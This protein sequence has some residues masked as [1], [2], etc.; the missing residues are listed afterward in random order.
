METY[1]ENR[2]IRRMN[3]QGGIKQIII[4]LSLVGLFLI[5]FVFFA[6]GTAANNHANQSIANVPG[7]SGLSQSLQTTLGQTIND[8]NDSNTAFANTQPTSG[9]S[10]GPVY[11]SVSAIWNTVTIVPKTIYTLTLG[12]II[13]NIF[14][15]NP[16]VKLI[17]NVLTGLLIIVVI[18]YAYLWIRLGNPDGNSSTT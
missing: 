13:D 1:E 17:A 2:M 6:L 14:G 9:S 8:A 7:M 16:N 10:L 3:K 15:G 18:L 12:V 4:N 5:A 11:D